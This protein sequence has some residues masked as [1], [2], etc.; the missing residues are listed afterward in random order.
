MK[1]LHL[2]VL[3]LSALTSAVIQ[4]QSLHLF[5][6]YY[7]AHT[8]G[9]SG[10]AERHLVQQEDGSYRLNM[11]L[12]AKVIGFRIGELEQASE[13][14]IIDQRLLP[15]HYS[16]LVS[17]ITSKAETVSFNWD[18]GVARSS[19]NEQSWDVELNDQVLD[20]MTYQLAMSLQLQTSDNT[21]FEFDIID[22]AEIATLKFRLLGEEILTTPMGRLNTVK[23]ERLREE[24]SRR[25]TLIWFAKDW[26]YLLAKIEQVNPSGLRIELELENALVSGEQVTA[27]P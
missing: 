2:L 15:R 22:G 5:S 7:Q 10:V 1:I 8:N 17:G 21:V 26:H 4:A 24:S 25:S 20:E 9:M 16:Y 19:K 18:A 11:S 14:E 23:V 13:F 27:L 6:S 12:E 3:A